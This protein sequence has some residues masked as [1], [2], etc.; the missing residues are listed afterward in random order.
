MPL[1]FVELPR[2]VQ[3]PNYA[4]IKQTNDARIATQEAVEAAR[5]AEAARQVQLAAEKAQA[6]Q[7]VSTHVVSLGGSLLD[8]I[9][10]CESSGNPR[11]T[12]GTHFGLFQF[13][14]GTWASVGGSG[15][16]MDASVSEQYM[17]AQILL[18]ERGTQPWDASRNCWG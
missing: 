1:V 18:N 9:A 12:N 10:R 13:D 15:N 2:P 14:L 16:P 5:Q 6:A 8:N 11:A 7:I 17:R 4:T 3:P